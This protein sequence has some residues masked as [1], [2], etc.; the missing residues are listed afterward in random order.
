MRNNRFD[1]S[2]KKT[3]YSLVIPIISFIIIFGFF[4]FGI[5]QIS[6]VNSR[7]QINSLD[8]TVSRDIM[9]FYASNGKYPETI[10]VLENHYGLTYDH[11][12]F[13]VQYTYKG[14]NVLPEYEILY[15]K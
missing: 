14:Y 6:G 15:I 8:T 5:N 1:N 12:H 10:D 2:K 3:K 4:Y 7:A 13:L 9:H 11:D